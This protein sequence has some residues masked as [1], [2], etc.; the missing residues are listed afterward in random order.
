M[1]IVKFFKNIDK[2]DVA[3]AGGKGASLG[4]MTQ[5]GIAV[6]LGFVVLAEAFDKFMELT[7]V[8]IELDAMWSRVEIEN[9][10]NLEENSAIIQDIILKKKFPEELEKEILKAFDELNAKDVAVRS[11]ATAE[12]SEQDA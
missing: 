3:I 9:T 8:N 11:S 7:D 12:D 6:P 4:E 10:D 2:K 5:A 1:K